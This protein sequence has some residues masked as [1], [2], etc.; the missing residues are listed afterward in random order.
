MSG[1]FISDE[2][3]VPALQKDWIPAEICLNCSRLEFRHVYNS[4]LR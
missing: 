3:S 4:G 1:I 2:R